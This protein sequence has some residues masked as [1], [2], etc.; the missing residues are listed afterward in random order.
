VILASQPN[1]RFVEVRQLADLA[2]FLC[3][4][5]AA[6]LTGASLPLDGGWTAR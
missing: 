6:S 2:L 3:S 1:K 5:A 4:D